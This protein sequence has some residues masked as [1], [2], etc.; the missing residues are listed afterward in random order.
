VL[1]KNNEYS[2]YFLTELD[3]SFEIGPEEDL[4][5]IMDTYTGPGARMLSNLRFNVLVTTKPRNGT[6][7]LLLRLVPR[8]SS[9]SILI[10]HVQ[11]MS[12]MLTLAKLNKFKDTRRFV[13]DTYAFYTAGHE[14]Y[15]IKDDFEVTLEER[16][17]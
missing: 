4:E 13:F 16:G 2:S 12:F 17:V 14:K 10:R 5:Y 9:G 6:N 11:E 7:W 15:P 1:V 3:I 8:S